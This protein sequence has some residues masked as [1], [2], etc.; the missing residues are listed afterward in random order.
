M[1]ARSLERETEV[2]NEVRSATSSDRQKSIERQFSAIIG[3]E[4]TALRRT[5]Q[6]VV[7]THAPRSVASSSRRWKRDARRAT[8]PWRSWHCGA[9]WP[10]SSGIRFDS[11]VARVIG[12]QEKVSPELGR[13]MNLI[14]PEIPMPA[15]PEK[16]LLLIAPPSMAAL[17]RRVALDIEDSWWS[18]LWKGRTSPS[19][20]GEQIEELIKAEFRPVADGLALT[21]E[22][23]LTNYAT[24][25]FQMSFGLCTNIIQAVTRRRAQLIEGSAS[26]S[27]RRTQAISSSNASDNAQVLADRMTRC[28]RHQSPARDHRPR[29]SR[30]PAAPAGGGAMMHGADDLLTVLQNAR[31]QL[32]ALHPLRSGSGCVRCRAGAHGGG[33]G[34]TAARRH[35]R[36][37]E[38]G[39]DRCCRSPARNGAASFQRCCQ[40]PSS[41][42]H[43]LCR[44]D[45]AVRSTAIRGAR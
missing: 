25:S 24:T 34:A 7:D 8:G 12:L 22:R 9:R 26:T 16:R 14:A 21:A 32:E 35:P 18:S 2:L 1:S 41:D 42:P 11:A 20:Y 31:R 39:Q 43:P 27:A 4:L 40:H 6:A 13:L 30:T 23:V 37:S 17:S 10:R 33:A 38:L 15:E 29:P 45:G 28:G 5:L 19:V 3:E 44:D 36:R